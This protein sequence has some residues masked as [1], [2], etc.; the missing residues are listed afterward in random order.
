[1]RRSGGEEIV[2]TAASGACRVSGHLQPVKGSDIGFALWLPAQWNG[3]FLMLG[4]GGYASAMPL[5]QMTRALAKGYAVAATDTG[6]QG[7]D[8]PSRS[9][10]RKRSP[11]GDGALFTKRRARRRA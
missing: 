11:T 2:A 4:N 9:A 6:H 3:R 1:M 7:D 10:I 5:E 8:P